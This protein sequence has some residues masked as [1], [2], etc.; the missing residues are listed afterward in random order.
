MQNA[1]SK[2][3]NV[4]EAGFRFDWHETQKGRC[5]S[6]VTRGTVARGLLRNFYSDIARDGQL[7]S[8][9]RRIYEV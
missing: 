5:E 4:G 8:H 6:R 1:R 7:T 3:P 9:N 2:G